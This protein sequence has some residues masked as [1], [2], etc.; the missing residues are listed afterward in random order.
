MGL[1]TICLPVELAVQS[2]DS[3]Y[4]IIGLCDAVDVQNTNMVCVGDGGL[5]GGRDVSNEYLRGILYHWELDPGQVH[6]YIISGLAPFSTYAC[7][8]I[9]YDIFNIPS[10]TSTVS[11]M[12]ICRFIKIVNRKYYCSD[13]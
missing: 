2:N 10:E 11:E 7:T 1:T 8:L 5:G 4:K 12:I 13:V 9:W 3:G 6:C